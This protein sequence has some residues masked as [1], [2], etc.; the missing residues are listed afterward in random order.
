MKTHPACLS[1]LGMVVAL[2]LARVGDG[3]AIAPADLNNL[4]H[5]MAE[6]VRHLGEDIAS[7]LGQT[8][9]GRHLLQD[10]Q[11]LAQAVD[12]FH[13][14]LHDNRDPAQTRQ[15]FAGIETTWQHLRGQLAR[16]SS[17]AVNRA[18]GRVDQLD[19]QIQQALG[20]NAPPAGFYGGGQ[21]PTGIADT[22][23]LAHALAA[24]AESLAAALQAD[25]GRD[26]NGAALTRDAMELA[27]SADAFHDSI[28]ANQPVEVAARAF[29]PVDAIADRMERFITTNQVPPRVQNAW[30]AFASVEILVHQ[31]L[32]LDSPQPQVQVGLAPPTGGGIPPIVGL[33]SQLVEQVNQ[34]VQVF[35]PTAG[36]V[37]EGGLMLIDAQRLQA[38]ASE[39]QRSAAGGLPPNQLAYGFRDVDALWQRLARRVNRVARGRMGPNIQQVQRVGETCEQIHRVLGMPGYPAMLGGPAGFAPDR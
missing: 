36:N 37:P 32:G 1:I 38:A 11:E 31:N 6:R 26:P 21:P 19:A 9:A 35:G 25:M 34:F 27:R 14:T 18:A 22:Q 4:V 30:Q 10:T 13:E 23:R 20:L 12:E 15:A 39:F 5:Q 33:S 2:G 17:P 29:A 3:Q 28:D 16:A 24:R 8:P 7:D